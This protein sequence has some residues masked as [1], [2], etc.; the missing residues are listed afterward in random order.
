MKWL[1]GPYGII[2]LRARA[3]KIKQVCSV[4]TRG[5]E[6]ERE[7][8]RKR[9]RERERERGSERERRECRREGSD[10]QAP[11]GLKQLVEDFPRSCKACSKN[12]WKWRR[13]EDKKKKGELEKVER[14]K[15]LGEKRRKRSWSLRQKS[16]D[17]AGSHPQL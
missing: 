11:L 5:G 15:Y 1:R 14:G 2:G 12:S 7:R 8:G 3:A 10:C 17:G 16:S 6:R 4:T 13:Q 9:E